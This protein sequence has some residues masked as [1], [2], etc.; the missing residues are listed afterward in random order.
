[1]SQDTTLDLDVPEPGHVY[2]LTGGHEEAAL[3]NGNS[4]A[5]SEVR[6]PVCNGPSAPFDPPHRPCRA[7]QADGRHLA[8]DGR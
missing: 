2:R 7:C 8:A 3:S 1:L 6:C 5:E 4:W